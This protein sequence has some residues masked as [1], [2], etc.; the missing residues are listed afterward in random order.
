MP[1]TEHLCMHAQALITSE[2]TMRLKFAVHWSIGVDGNCPCWEVTR[3]EDI[4]LNNHLP[5]PRFQCI[6]NIS[7]NEDGPLEWVCYHFNQ[8]C[9][10][11]WH[12]YTVICN[13]C[14]SYTGP[15]QFDVSVLWWKSYFHLAYRKDGIVSETINH[16]FEYLSVKD[17]TGPVMPT[18]FNPKLSGIKWVSQWMHCLAA[19]V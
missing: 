15:T 1:S 17:V 6:Q 14:P 12:I 16:L 10:P 9:L 3:K 11:C 4:T 18:P 8:I 5:I 13:E 19:A 7:L 2:W